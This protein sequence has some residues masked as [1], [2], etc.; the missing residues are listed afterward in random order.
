M[1]ASGE[2][3][4]GHRRLERRY[5]RL[6]WAYPVGYR[7]AHGDEILAM[8]MDSAEPGRRRPARADV[9]DLLRGA[10]RQW[11]RLPIGKAAVV[12]AV[13][14]AVVLGAVGAAASSWLGR[15]TTRLVSDP[16]AVRTVETMAGVPLAMPQIE[17]RDGPRELWP[18]VDVLPDYEQP[19]PNWTIEAAQ[20]RLRANGWT[21]GPVERSTSVRSYGD[22]RHDALHQ[23][24]QATK[25]GQAVTGYANTVLAPG[26]A[27]TDLRVTVHPVRPGEEW[28]AIGLGWL[29]GAVAGW[30]LSGWA[31]YR[32]RRSA[33]PR[34]LAAL[35]LGLIAVGLAAHPT[36]G[37]YDTLGKH[38]FTDPGV[39]GIAPAYYWVVA[40]PAA[41]L[42]AATL[43]GG[44]ALLAVAATTRR[45]AIS[46]TTST[47]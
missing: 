18:G 27:G 46:L 29:V 21:I 26:L 33:L 35:A 28:A 7:R 32:L 3:M 16:T 37:L 10:V 45:P 6:L 40:Y 30:L 4:P 38:A 15:Q 24:F 19:V 34:R 39:Y 43:A 13:L 44:L 47:T 5:R 1:T 14:S 36:I 31:G 11:F 22:E 2:V 25:D 23:V 41:A 17:R 12:A 20:A 42:V 9:L 8:L